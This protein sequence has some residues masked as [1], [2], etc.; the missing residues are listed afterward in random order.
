MPAIPLGYVPADGVQGRLQRRQPGVRHRQ[1]Q[2]PDGQGRPDFPRRQ[3]RR[4]QGRGGR[5]EQHADQ[6]AG[7]HLGRSARRLPAARSASTSSTCRTSRSSTPTSAPARSRSAACGPAPSRI[8]AAGQ[9][10]PDPIALEAT[11]P[12]PTTVARRDAQAAADEP[13][14]R[15]IL[16]PDGTP[17]GEGVIIK[18]KSDEFK[19]FCSEAS[20]GE[21]RCTTI[22]QGIQE[23]MRRHRC[24]RHVPVRRRQRR[25]LHAD[26][27][28][29]RR[30]HRT[31]GAAARIGPRRRESATSSSSCSASPISW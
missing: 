20:I 3:R 23:A 21:C 27:V 11:M 7:R 5:R 14:D 22:P 18:Y 12:A 24:R 4:R 25:Q 31:D 19:T 9:F 2:Q 30:L 26:R 10:S 29:A 17:V 8:R 6:G 15:Q 1:V 28:R 13:G 16:K